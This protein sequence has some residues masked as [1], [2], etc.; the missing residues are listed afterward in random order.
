MDID[1]LVCSEMVYGDI[2]V[3]DN[4]GIVEYC[5]LIDHH[6]SQI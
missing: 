3:V 5:I 4:E 1:V 6:K 2:I